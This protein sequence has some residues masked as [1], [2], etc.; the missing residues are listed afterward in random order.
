ME[1]A[2]RKGDIDEAIDLFKNVKY[3]SVRTE[4]ALQEVVD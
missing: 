1:L 4:R 3:F 2:C